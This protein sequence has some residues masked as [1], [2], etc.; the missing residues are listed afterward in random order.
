MVAREKDLRRLF[1][2]IAISMLFLFLFSNMYSIS[3]CVLDLLLRQFPRVVW[4]ECLGDIICSLIY[5]ACFLFPGLIFYRI[6]RGEPCESVSFGGDLP[7]RNPFLKTVAIVCISVGAILAMSYLNAWLLPSVS[8]TGGSVGLSKP[9]KVILLVFSSAIVPAF[10]EELLFR[11]IILSN[12]KPYGKGMAVVVSALLFGLMHMNAAQLLYATAAGIVLGLVYVKTNSLWICILIHFCNNMFSVLENY[13]YDIFRVE[14]AGKICM[15]A[16]LFI[17]FIAILAAL[18]CVLSKK[19]Q[20]TK[21]AVGVF[22][23]TK[24]LFFDTPM[25]GKRVLKQF[26]CPLMIVYLVAAVLNMIYVLVYNLTR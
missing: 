7:T 6:S 8:Y 3:C 17:F 13:M 9:Y 24:S 21:D 4:L 10:S 16:E 18:I 15:L 2:K 11:G 5:F 14:T 1:T 26:L 20:P 23:E 22:G 12:L 19:E 25:N